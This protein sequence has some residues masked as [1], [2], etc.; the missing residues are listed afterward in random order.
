M[1]STKCPARAGIRVLA[2]MTGTFIILT[3]MAGNAEPVKTVN[4]TPI[5]SMVLDVYMQNRVNK[6]IA[7][8]TAEERET[9]TSELTDIYVLS[10]QDSAEDLEKDPKV[11]AQIELQKRG[12]LAQ[13]VA[14]QFFAEN[15]VSE[16]EVQ[17]EYSEQV[18][19][20]PPL[21]YKARHI[22]VPTQGVATDVIKRLDEGANFEELAKEKSTGP[23]APNGGDL[24]WF[25]P[26]QMVPAFSDSVAQ[27]DDGAYTKEPVKTEFGWHVILREDSRKTEA[28]PLDSVREAITQ[29]VQQKKFQEHLETLR[30]AAA[31]D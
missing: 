27:L 8:V 14:T 2:A 21:Q 30:A 28:P 11:A 6:P 25:A 15:E 7:Q 23:S 10:T 22:L 1:I 24:G 16:E 12:V 31:A 19:L 3:G 17:A 29:S 9:L 5:D 13:A 18:K 26:N 20:A 4:G